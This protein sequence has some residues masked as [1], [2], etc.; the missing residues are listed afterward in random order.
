MLEREHELARIEELLDAARDGTGGLLLIAG[1]AGIGKTSLLGQCGSAAIGRGMVVL[2]ARGDEVAMES[3]FAVARELLWPEAERDRAGALS[4]AARLAEPVFEASGE[5]AIDA[6]RTA[7][8]LHGLHWLVANLAE[9]SPLVLLVDD[10]HWLDPAS[11][12]FLVYLSRRIDSLPVLL[13][14]A[15]RS[16]EVP[17]RSGLAALSESAAERLA[18]G[19]LSEHASTV[20]VRHELGP[21]ADEELCR[22]CYEA[23]AGNPFY[24]HALLAALRAEGGRPSVEVAARLRALGAGAVGRSVLVR[25]ARLGPDCERLAEAVAVLAASSPLRHAASLAGLER[26]AAQSA[27]DRLCQADLLLMDPGLSFAHPIVREAV[28][29]E[30]AP[31][32]KAG[33]HFEAAR[34]LAAEGAPADRVAAH[35]LSAERFGEQWVVDAL[36]RAARQAIA[37]GAPEAAVSYLRRALAEPPAPDARVDLL[38]ELGSAEVQIPAV[39]DFSA[40]REALE[41]ADS[42]RRRAE[43]ACELGWAL[44]CLA[45]N[46][47]ARIMLEQELESA[48][49]LDPE[50]VERL[51]ALLIGGGAP[52]LTARG[53]HARLAGNLDRWRRG[54]ARDPPMLAALAQTGAVMGF[55]VH[56][57]AALARGAIADER[58][59]DLWWPAYNGAV[60]ALS[61]ADELDEAAS[62]GDAGL[63]AAQ[64]RGVAPMFVHMALMRAQTALRAGELELAEMYSQRAL[65]VA[66]ELGQGP[67]LWA[68]MWHGSVLLE[69]GRAEEAG[70]LLEALPI[71][72]VLGLWQGLMLL[73]DRGRVRVAL[74]ELERGIADLIEADQRAR[75]AGCH[76]GVLND[77]MPGAALALDRLGRREQALEL[78]SRELADAAAFGAQRRHGIALSVFGLI[79]PR[80]EGLTSLRDAARILE[81]SPARLEHAR[82]LVNLGTGLHARGR[83]EEAREPLL[84]G[85]DVAHRCGAVALA[86]QARTELV[87]TGAR[88][89]RRT[90]TGPDALT[91]AELRTA[92]MAAEGLSNREIAQALFLTTKT[93]EWQLSHAYAKLQVRGRG[94]LACPLADKTPG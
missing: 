4:G 2:R 81:H 47:P 11:A 24:L 41:L 63:A 50:L 65:A 29:A 71:E 94:E 48:A 18:P 70:E 10:G 27:A 44:V 74:G 69:R 57:V 62:A 28:A 16:G 58:L 34:L 42:S 60:V 40:L 73:A 39:T 67:R 7:S 36:R 72:R 66:E 3:S 45:Q 23:V 8:V 83:R 91:P 53:I 37:Q 6:E 80:P 77:W 35:L 15:A 31:A 89:R 17:D 85:L 25:L 13:A 76:L 55:R 84:R 88:P 78:A 21:R 43:I 59:L 46:K 52:D 51:E 61:W 1:P 22:S 93:V 38:V 20:I 14:V 19:A 79:D 92:R 82:A 54:E 86:E 30:L 68:T 26:A 33:L 87:A 9:R 56:D 32:S 49:E 90:L 12:R 5:G 64:R 75:S